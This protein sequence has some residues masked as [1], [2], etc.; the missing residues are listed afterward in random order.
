[1]LKF[2]LPDVSER[3]SLSHLATTVHTSATAR[4]FVYLE[5]RVFAEYMVFR[6]KRTRPESTEFDVEAWSKEKTRIK[7]LFII[8]VDCKRWCNKK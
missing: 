6:I 1:M 8:N 4:A 2:Y 7:I 3:V 5:C